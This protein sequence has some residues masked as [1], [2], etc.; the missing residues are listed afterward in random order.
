MFGLP[1][2]PRTLEASLRDLSS[3][4]EDV[5]RSAIRDLTRLAEGSDAVR[6]KALPLL[7]T[8]LSSDEEPSVRTEA[9]TALADLRAEECLPTLIV[10]VDPNDAG[11]RLV[12]TL[13]GALARHCRVIPLRLSGIDAAGFAER[14]GDAALAAQLSTH[15]G[16]ALAA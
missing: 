8:A 10:A 1:P 2:L 3:K 11:E 5:R 12:D 6:A 14:Y 13:R 16:G 15:L 7:A 4:K 9:A